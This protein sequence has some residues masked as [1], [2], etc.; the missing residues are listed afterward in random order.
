MPRFELRGLAAFSEGF[1]PIS[2]L[3]STVSVFG[4]GSG[5]GMNTSDPVLL[6]VPVLTAVTAGA[7]RLELEIFRG[8]GEEEFLIGH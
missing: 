2:K 8:Q 4:H 7:E 6:G 3:V 5:Q 1:L